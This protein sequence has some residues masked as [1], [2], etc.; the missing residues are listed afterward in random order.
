MSVD[1]TGYFSST[2]VHCPQCLEK[3]SKSGVVEYSHQ[4][5]GACMVH[6]DLKEVLPLC[7]EPI[8]KQD[9]STKND[10]ERNASKRLIAQIAKD[11]PTKRFIFV[12]DSLYGNAP[13]INLLESHRY[14]YIIAVKEG[15]HKYLFEQVEHLREGGKLHCYQQQEQGL[16]HQ[17]EYINQIPL[18]A[19]N[20]DLLVNLLVY[21]QIKNG[22][23]KYFTWITNITLKEPW[24]LKIM[25]AGRARWKIENETF[26][27][28]KNQGY[29]FE[30]NFGHG[31]KNLSV[32]L[33]MMM[34]LAFLIDQIQQLCCKVFNEVWKK[35]GS[36]KLLWYEIRKKF[37]DY[38][39]DSMLQVYQIILNPLPKIRVSQ[40]LDSS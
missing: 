8:I 34:M 5:L 38:I 4:M 9:G 21:K 3:R 30:H 12:E 28:L 31:Y 19:S 18:N 10:C 17:F 15:D 29:Q 1:G 39:F 2:K 37:E 40:L 24:L 7:P 13:H 20:E 11:H 14:K 6:P 26:N 36:K 22:Q 32:N 35:L 23:T 16:I 25:R 33:A 27:T